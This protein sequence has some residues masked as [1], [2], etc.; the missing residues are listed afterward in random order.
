MTVNDIWEI[1]RRAHSS[2]AIPEDVFATQ[3]SRMLSGIGKASDLDLRTHA[4]DIFLVT[5]CLLGDAAALGV[6]EREYFAQVPRFVAP[7]DRRP[8]FAQEVAQQLR[9]R[10]L[11]PSSRKLADYAAAGPLLAWLRVSARRLAIDLQRH[12]GFEGRHISAGEPEWGRIAGV[13][14]PEWEV[15]R[16]RYR[17]PVEVAIKQ[18]VSS[19][20][21]QE[22]MVLRLYLLGGENIEKIGKTYGVHRATVARWISAAQEKVVTAVRAELRERFGISES[23]CDSLARDLRSRL[24]ISLGGLL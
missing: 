5:A 15:L 24:D 18:A 9:E 20:S 19:L 4:G 13:G 8:D 21:S 12:A 23:E 6:L 17:E 11:S 14:N 2:V 7:I 22:R 16:A 3:M 10:L 1:G